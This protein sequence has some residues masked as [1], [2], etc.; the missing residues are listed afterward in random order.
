MVNCENV[1][2][3]LCQGE[4]I[5]IVFNTSIKVIVKDNKD[6]IK[7]PVAQYNCLSEWTYVGVILNWKIVKRY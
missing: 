1:V 5:V 3:Y 7:M 4:R 2:N 6:I